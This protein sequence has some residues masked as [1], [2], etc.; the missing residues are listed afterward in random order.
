MI[1]IEINSLET[2]LTED[3]NGLRSPTT[4]VPV[5]AEDIDLIVTPG[6]AFDATGGRLGRGGG[7]YDTFFANKDLDA[8]EMGFCFSEQIVEEVPMNEHDRRV[9]VVVSDDG[10]IEIN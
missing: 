2:G 9:D 1:A 6:L 8:V 5:P 10:V 7:Y 3:T 4:G